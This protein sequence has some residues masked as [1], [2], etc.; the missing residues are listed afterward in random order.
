MKKDVHL[1][2]NGK[3]SALEFSHVLSSVKDDVDYFH[4]R[5]RGRTSREW[6]E[7]VEYLLSKGIPA[8]KL[9]IHDRIDI[10][11][12]LGIS[13][14]QLGYNSIDV[15]VVK[16]AY[17]SLHVGC[18]VH[19]FAEAFEAKRKGADSILYGHIYETK[20]KERLPPRG[21]EELTRIVN[22][23]GIKTVAIG[24]ILPKNV[25]AV[26][27]SGVKGIA[28]M[29]GIIEAKDPMLTAHAYQNSIR[30]WEKRI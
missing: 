19:S 3:L 5:E 2:S 23:I 25:E 7:F 14:V 12:L 8:E 29:S 10:A 27:D 17:P 26:L 18:S 22:E 20:S 28:V 24:G 11:L 13:H 16:N 9:V 15:E 6:Y 21:L 30:K 4:I 1:I